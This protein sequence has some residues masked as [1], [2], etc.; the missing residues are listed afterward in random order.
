MELIR[1]RQ[2]ILGTFDMHVAEVERT[3]QVAAGGLER[4]CLVKWQLTV[5]SHVWAKLGDALLEH[6]NERHGLLVLQQASCCDFLTH[7]DII[8]AA[9]GGIVVL[10]HGIDTNV[11]P[12]R[13]S[14]RH[15][16]R[17]FLRLALFVLGG[18]IWTFGFA[19]CD[20][21]LGVTDGLDGATDIQGR[22][23]HGSVLWPRWL[24][25]Q[26]IVD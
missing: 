11:L 12:S 19:A 5:E 20:G 3:L 9:G 17:H 26:G 7:L 18:S 21:D 8:N 6:H 1:P 25:E 4:F 23:R 22:C 13:E 10:L 16:D 24:G 15:K 14:I 2:G